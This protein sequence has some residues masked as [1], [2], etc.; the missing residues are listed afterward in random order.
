MSICR[1]EPVISFTLQR[2]DFQTI[3]VRTGSDGQL[4]GKPGPAVLFVCFVS[5]QAQAGQQRASLKQRELLEQMLMLRCAGG[6]CPEAL[7]ASQARLPHADG[8]VAAC[9]N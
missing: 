6:A 7:K 2:R 9:M 1:L 5:A 3:I 8:K 4:L